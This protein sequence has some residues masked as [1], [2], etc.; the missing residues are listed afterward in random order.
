MRMEKAFPRE[1]KRAKEE[2][3]PLI[4]PV[5]TME[6]HGPHCAFGCDTLIV[7]GLLERLEAKRDVVIYPPV[8]YGVSSYAVAGPEKDSVT[9]DVDVFEANMYGILKSL[10]YGGWKNIYMV[11]HH[12]YEDEI[13]NPM[14]LA[15]MKAAKKLTFEYLEETMGTGWWGRNDN[16]DFY[17]ELESGDNPWNWI[18][19]LPAMSK[20]AQHATGYDHA[21]EF[22]T[23]LLMALYPETV[24]LDRLGESDEWF[25]NSAKNASAELGEKMAELSLRALDERIK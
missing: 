17:K 7:E 9:V 13:P 15:C 1:A 8:W 22:E 20:E 14:T 18:T 10:L 23:S 4:I 21:G 16:Q 3:W 11:I 19:V 12:Q 5:G 6:Y 2:R 24:A 25:I